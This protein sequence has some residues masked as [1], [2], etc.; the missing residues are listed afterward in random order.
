MQSYLDIHIHY[1]GRRGV[2]DRSNEIF[3]KCILSCTVIP[4]PIFVCTA[5]LVRVKLDY[6]PSFAV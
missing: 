5:L 1:R 4:D 2:V 3:N 6:N